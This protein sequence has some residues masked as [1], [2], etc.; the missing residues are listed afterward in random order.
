MRQRS[1]LLMRLYRGPR[2]RYPVED[3][4]KKKAR[5]RKSHTKEGSCKAV[6]VDKSIE[7]VPKKKAP[8][9]KKAAQKKGGF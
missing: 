2:G 9:K 4:P 1:Q 8:T 5:L 6:A 7:D 3:A